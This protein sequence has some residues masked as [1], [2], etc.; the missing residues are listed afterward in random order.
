MP[1][2][3][4][5]QKFSQ[6]GNL[7]KKS[8]KV[9][10]ATHEEP[11]PDA[12]GSLIA[13]GMALEKL[14]IKSHL[15]CPDPVAKNLS[16]FP[17]IEL[18]TNKLLKDNVDL[19]IGLD[20]GD[21][22]R[23]R[24]DKQWPVI[25]ITLDHHPQ[26]GQIGDIKIIDSHFSSTCE[27]IYWLLKTMRLDLDKDIATCLLAG[28]FA[29]TGGFQHTNTTQKV[30]KVAGKLLL[31]GARIDKISGQITQS[32]NLA[33]L[34]VCG[35]ALSKIKKDPQTGMVVSMLSQD[36]IKSCQASPEDL[37]GIPAILNTVSGGK[38]SLLLAEY[39]KNGI[40]GSLRS[41]KY[42]G[43]DVSQIA[44]NLGGGGHK[45]AAGFKTEGELKEVLNKVKSFVHEHEPKAKCEG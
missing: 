3:E 28:I 14:K 8:K 35:L 30:L 42:K 36:D 45:L 10:I 9:L 22:E 37:A 29:D 34:K 20:Y 38:L 33:S 7:I 1:N 12:I 4:L 23:I 13:L 27:I 15:F 16:F 44:K 31:G 24:I 2:Q 6:I 5:R 32:K 39:K 25:I 21:W 11:D 26:S 17:R 19:V 43:I 40:K 41:E 18:V